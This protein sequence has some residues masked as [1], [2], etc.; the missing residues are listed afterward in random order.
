MWLCQLEQPVQDQSKPNAAHR[1]ADAVLT[2]R[3]KRWHMRAAEL[4]AVADEFV[5]PSAQEGLRSAAIYYE[6]LADQAAAKL[7]GE[8]TAST[9]E[10]G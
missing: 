2:E 10:G 5:I 3:I 6:R 1:A 7:S 9:E 8:P 4:R